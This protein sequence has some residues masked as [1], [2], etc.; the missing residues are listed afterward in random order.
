MSM[1]AEPRR[2]KAWILNPRKSQWA[3]DDSKFGQ[4]MLEQ[5]GWS[6]GKGLGKEMAG[7][8]EHIRPSVQNDSR[9][10]GYE[11][12]TDDW[13]AHLDDFNDLL[14][15][16]QQEQ[17]TG[18]D[19]KAKSSVKSLEERSKKSRARV[20]YHKFTRGKD[21]SRYSSQDLASILGGRSEGGAASQPVTPVSSRPP[22]P[23]P[24]ADSEPVSEAE[25]EPAP[26]PAPELDKSSGYTTINT[27][28]SVKDYLAAKM[29]KMKMLKAKHEQEQTSWNVF[30]ENSVKETAEEPSIEPKETHESVEKEATKSKKKKKKRPASSTEEAS[31]M[32]E[33]ENVSEEPRKKKRKHASN[34]EETVEPTQEE[35]GTATEER[36]KKKKRKNADVNAEESAESTA[37][38]SPEMSSAAAPSEEDSPA[39][40]G[41]E[42]TT[43]ETTEA[44]KKKKKKRKNIDADPAERAQSA[45]DQSDELSSAAAPPAEGTPPA[46]AASEQ[47]PSDGTSEAPSKKKKKRKKNRSKET[48]STD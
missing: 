37:D 18:G 11:G 47:A 39:G 17:E 31:P 46:A 26:A 43:D 8:T 19:S 13:V 25:T 33:E 42:Q 2:K 34:V 15:N 32:P 29:M 1:L 4:K 48:E 7:I 45:A 44:P 6:K 16:L 36:K 20:H 41:I 30:D 35:T 14:A 38:Q 9:G 24:H 23:P 5:M 28:L 22:S 3:E 10:L 21:L 27:G 40:G 12:R